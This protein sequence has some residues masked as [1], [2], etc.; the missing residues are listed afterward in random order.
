MMLLKHW[1]WPVLLLLSTLATS[2][3]WLGL[4]RAFD[5]PVVVWFLCVC[6]GMAY[7]RF[8]N[9]AEPAVEWML[10]LALSFAIDALVATMLLYR[11]HWSPQAIL[12]ILIA[13]SL[14]GTLAQLIRARSRL[15]A[16]GR[17]RA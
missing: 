7:V 6:P 3:T 5:L 16:P 1:G 14:C 11:G 15:R 12:V 17:G 2:L 4:P 13:I 8:L 10:A 9:I